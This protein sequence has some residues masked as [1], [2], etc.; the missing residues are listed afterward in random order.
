M[1]L[2]AVLALRGAT[3][4]YAQFTGTSTIVTTDAP[5]QPASATQSKAQ[6]LERASQ[7]LGNMGKTGK[8]KDTFTA[9][10]GSTG[11]VI[12]SPEGTFVGWMVDGVQALFVGAKFDRQGTNLTQQEM[13][14]RGYATPS[15]TPTA[16]KTDPTP[17][18]SDHSAAPRASDKLLKAA[19]LSPGITEGDAG[20]LWIVYID[21]N[22]I[23]CTQLWRNLRNPIASGQ[24][25][26]RW[27]PVAVVAP[28]STG[29]AA[30]VLQS[31]RPIA[32]LT[33][34]AQG[35]P[36]PTVTMSESTVQKIEANNSMLRALNAGKVAA[37][38]TIVIPSAQGA[39]VITGL[40]PDLQTLIEQGR[41]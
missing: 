6:R 17:Q 35:A 12:E 32:L 2:L 40:P 20:P 26:V 33:Q 9:T 11:V 29:Q 37:T 5:G 39:R 36:F 22:C 25:R 19:A 34:H 27:A 13:I 14:A 16:H 3:A 30:A 7:L 38:P 10:D 31:D 41:S 15:I 8:V 4:F 24:L 28:S 18:P 1:A 23:Y 21:G